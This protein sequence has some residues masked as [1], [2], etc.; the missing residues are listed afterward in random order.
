[1]AIAF[2][3][4]IPLRYHP[5]SPHPPAL[6]MKVPPILSRERES[7][8]VPLGGCL[9]S[10]MPPCPSCL[11]VV[12]A[13]NIAETSLTIDGIYYVVDPGFVKQK[14]YNSKTGID[15][16][17][18]TPISQVWQLLPTAFL[19]ILVRAFLKFFMVLCFELYCFKIGVA[20]LR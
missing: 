5:P 10:S 3:L 9:G 15:Q 11:Q 20:F 19:K 12:I 8:T 6:K 1:M 18:V 4:C 17:V 16:L 2:S 7:H 14:V 13:T